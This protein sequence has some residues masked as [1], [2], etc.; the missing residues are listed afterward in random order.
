MFTD[1][2]SHTAQPMRVVFGR[3]LQPLREQVWELGV[4]RAV[5]ISTP[6]RTALA[7]E[8]ADTIGSAVIDVLG[9]A[10]MHVPV[11]VVDQSERRCRYLG[12]D[13]YIAV[14][15]GSAI[16]FAKALA[17]RTG[18]PVIAIPTTYGGS[19]MTPVWGV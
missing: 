16:G 19:E 1:S 14:G 3:G 10:V 18:A 12:C 15:G 7:R 8:V 9:E 5:V 11:A 17:L 6:G 2:F 13:G 4:S